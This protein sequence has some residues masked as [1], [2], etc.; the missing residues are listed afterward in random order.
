MTPLPFLVAVTCYLVGPWAFLEFPRTQTADIAGEYSFVRELRF[1]SGRYLKVTTTHRTFAADTR[2]GVPA[3]ATVYYGFDSGLRLR[4]EEFGSDYRAI[5]AW[6][7]HRGRVPSDLGPSDQR[8]IEGVRS[9]SD[10]QFETV[11]LVFETD[12]KQPEPV[13]HEVAVHPHRD[14]PVARL[15]HHRVPLPEGFLGAVG[16]V[17]DAAGVA[18]H[19]AVSSALPSAGGAPPSRAPR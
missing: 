15:D 6:L 3:A 11:P 9:W 16:E 12:R 13:V 17:Q 19:A 7:R 10:G 1:D 4:T 8:I 5:H 18:G 2:G 14:G